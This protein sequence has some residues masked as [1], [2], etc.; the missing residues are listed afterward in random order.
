MSMATT[1][2]SAR[3]G[4]LPAGFATVK[5]VLEGEIPDGARRNIMGIL[6]DF[7]APIPTR[8]SGMY[9]II[10]FYYTPRFPYTW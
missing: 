10:P 4:K 1:R 6:T 7:R 8:G 3:Q 2:A 5:D 9:R